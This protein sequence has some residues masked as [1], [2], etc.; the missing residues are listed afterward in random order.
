[1]GRRRWR[2]FGLLFADSRGVLVASVPLSIL[3][4]ALLVPVA[5][6]VRRVFDT[7]VPRGDTTAIVLSGLLVFALYLASAAL[8]LLTSHMVLKATRRAVTRLRGQ[9]M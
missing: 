2:S 9:L 3:E 5:L 8:G 6:V 7:L 1:M 4:A